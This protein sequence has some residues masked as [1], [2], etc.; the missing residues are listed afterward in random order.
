MNERVLVLDF[1]AQYAQLIARRVRELGVYAEIVP[2][3]APYDEILARRPAALILSGGPDSVYRDGAPRADERLLGAGIPLLGICYGMQYIAY[4]LG[5]CVQ[6]GRPEYGPAQVHRTAAEDPLL[7]G[8]PD[9][10]RV[11]MSHGDRVEQLPEGF[12]SLL[13]SDGAPCAA[14]GDRRRR[15]Y[16]VQFHPEVV[17]TEHGMEILRSFLYA[18]AGVHGTW[19]MGS[20]LEREVARIR[21][22][23]GEGSALVAL[24]GG[25]DSAVAAAI[26]H[27]AIGDR[28]T[29][30]FV[31]HGFLRDGE[32]DEVEQTFTERVPLR[33][34]R[35]PAGERFLEAL[36]GVTDP[37]LKRKRIGNLFIRVFEE[38]AA[39]V[40]PIDFLVQGTLYPDVIESGPGQA[41]VIKSHHNV[42]GLPEDLRFRLLE[43]LRDLFK[44]EVRRLGEELGLPYGLVHRQPF[45]GPG[46]AIRMVGEVQ[47]DRLEVLR[48]ADLVVRREVEAAGLAEELWQWFAVLPGVRTVGVMGDHRTYGE[49]VVVRAVISDD[50]MTADWAKLDPA[51][52]QRIA[53]ALVSEVPGV[54]RVLYDITSKPPG[55]IEWE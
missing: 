29:A 45:P 50:G 1:G 14:M 6:P 17:H 43:P 7:A 49:A 30:V 19:D 34:I 23:V 27:R 13:A 21:A 35:V 40:G 51:L 36:R 9:R 2:A 55:T 12:Q 41:A 39:K 5:G 10:F 48:R 26:V 3:D 53:S 38:E 52:L 22:Q 28:L 11:W 54:N 18:I 46:L 15:I 32:A 24:S 33:L 37:E 31:D 47:A 25:V 16:A 42:G 8:L 44:D 20:F 4:L